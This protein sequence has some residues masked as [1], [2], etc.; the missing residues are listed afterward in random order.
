MPQ[1]NVNF[2]PR[3]S[4]FIRVGKYPC[5]LHIHINN[6]RRNVRKHC[7]L[8]DIF[9]LKPVKRVCVRHKPSVARSMCALR[10]VLIRGGL[11]RLM[12][13]MPTISFLGNVEGRIVP[14]LRY[15]CQTV[16]VTSG[17]YALNQKSAVNSG[18][19]VRL[20]PL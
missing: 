2:L 14:V 20:V 10:V 15:G 7:V 1:K 4:G 18:K 3:F 13:A 16:V 19:Q 12:R 11:R 5:F 8:D 6:I 9:R 17:H